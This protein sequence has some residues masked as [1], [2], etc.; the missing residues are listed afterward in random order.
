MQNDASIENLKAMT[1]ATL[2]YGVY[3]SASSPSPAVAAP[4]GG[5]RPTPG[6]PDWVTAPKVRPGV[7][8]PWEAKASELPL[9]S[10]GPALLRRVWEDIEGLAYLYIWHLVLSF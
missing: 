2:E 5:D 6:L 3:R 10:G 4:A 7:C 1:G 8:F 9:I